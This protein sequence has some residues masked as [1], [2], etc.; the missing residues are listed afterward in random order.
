MGITRTS[1]ADHRTSRA[2]AALI[3]GLFAAVLLLGWASPASA[4]TDDTEDLP[5]TIAGNVR[6]EGEPISGATV[7]VT[8]ADGFESEATTE[9]NGS[10]RIGV[11]TKDTPYTV[12]L[13]L[14]SGVTAPEGFENSIEVEF[15]ATSTVTRNFTL[16]AA[17]RVTTSFWDQLASRTVNGLNFGLMLALAA[18]GVSLVFGTTGLSNFAH[19]EMVT[20]WRWSRPH[21]SAYRWMRGSGDHCGARASAPCS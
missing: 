12:E 9:D 21:S 15:G 1:R 14:P 10:F 20:F 8:G 3:A 13:D 6:T 16:S 7:T 19:G 4:Q 11:P 2:I 18:I 17:E 5:F